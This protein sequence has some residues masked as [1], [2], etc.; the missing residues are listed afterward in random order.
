MGSWALAGDINGDGFDDIAIGK[1]GETLAGLANAGEISTI[2]GSFGGLNPPDALLSQNSPGIPNIAELDDEFGASAC[3]GDFDGNGADDLA[4]GI[5]QEDI[6]AAAT[7]QGAVQVLYSIVGAG[8]SPAD[9]FFVQGIGGI[10]DGHEQSD[11]FGYS[12]AVGDLFNDGADD[13]IIGVPYEDVPGPAGMANDAGLVQIIRSVPG[14]G[15][16]PFANRAIDQG[17]PFIPGTVTTA[18]LFGIAVACG[19]FNAPAD[20]FDDIAIGIPGDDSVNV[21]AGLVV[22]LYPFGPPVAS[23]DLGLT[24]GVADRSSRR[25]GTARRAPPERKLRGPIV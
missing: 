11:G 12:L 2:L 21:D 13:L 24:G 25:S 15:L 6:G 8:L 19:D 22:V 9:Q 20:M 17:A 7:D 10:L 3:M 1:P 23:F 18:N 16:Q 5:P 4:I 14:A